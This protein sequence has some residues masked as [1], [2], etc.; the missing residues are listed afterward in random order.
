[1]P[2]LNLGDEHPEI[3]AKGGIGADRRAR[4]V[5]KG[6][7]QVHKA[8]ERPAG[9]CDRG[10]IQGLG[11]FV[12]RVRRRERGK[13]QR[14]ECNAKAQVEHSLDDGQAPAHDWPRVGQRER[15]GGMPDQ[16]ANQGADY[17][18]R[19]HS[20]RDRYATAQRKTHRLS[21]GSIPTSWAKRKGA[22]FSDDALTG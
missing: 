12:A 16:Q 8:K 21:L 1:L 3:L 22:T 9:R 14:A 6:E 4:Y 5:G 13:H 18:R 11:Q 7:D 2:Q 19:G 17:C 10:Q 20:N 15:V